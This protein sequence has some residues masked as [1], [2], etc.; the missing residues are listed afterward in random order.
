MLRYKTSRVF[1]HLE[2]DDFDAATNSETNFLLRPKTRRKTRRV[3]RNKGVHRVKCAFNLGLPFQCR[4][5][6]LLCLRIPPELRD[7]LVN[8]AEA[9]GESLSIYVEALL[10]R[11]FSR[12]R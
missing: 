5:N 2:G 4:K 9:K 3:N 10:E 8:A 6:V 7:E 1:A 12:K 11:H